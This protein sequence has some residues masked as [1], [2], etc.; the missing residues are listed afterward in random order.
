ML[1]HKRQQSGG[2]GAILCDAGDEGEKDQVKVGK[3]IFEAH[4][5]I[6]ERREKNAYVGAAYEAPL[7]VSGPVQL[8]EDRLEGAGGKQSAE[9]FAQAAVLFEPVGGTKQRLSVLRRR[10]FFG[11]V[12]PQQAVKAVSARVRS[13]EG[14]VA[15]QSGQ[16]CG[17]LFA[18]HR[19]NGLRGREGIQ[20]REPHKYRA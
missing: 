14:V 11:Q 19:V 18:A 8:F 6:V 4:L 17:R 7:R 3:R 2:F 13:R 1:L 20:R 10:P 5:F 12:R 16:Q 15:R 9:R